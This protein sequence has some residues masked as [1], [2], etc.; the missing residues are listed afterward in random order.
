MAESPED[1][2]SSACRND[3]CD[4]DTS[5]GEGYDG[6]CGNCADRAEHALDV[7]GLDETF[8]EELA[9]SGYEPGDMRPGRARNGET[10]TAWADDTGTWLARVQFP[11]P[12]YGPPA[13]DTTQLHRIRKRARY[14][15][16]RERGTHTAPSTGR[17]LHLEIHEIDGD[18]RTVVR[19][20]TFRETAA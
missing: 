2:D 7:L 1:D 5:D 17:A 14:V 8:F 6:F 20:M 13:L 3:W 11:S 4:D 19:S 16:R 12:G 9:Q 15:I 18:P 10:V